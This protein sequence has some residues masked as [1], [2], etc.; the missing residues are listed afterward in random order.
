MV[1]DVARKKAT[2]LT[3]MLILGL[4]FSLGGG[5][6]LFF[7]PLPGEIIQFDEYVSDG[8]KP[9]TSSPGKQIEKQVPF[10]IIGSMVDM[11]DG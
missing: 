1:A 5:F 8:L 11:V 9:P 6:K 10:P 4:K 2:R 7:I 3:G